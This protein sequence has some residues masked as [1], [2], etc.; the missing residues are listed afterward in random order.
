MLRAIKPL[1]LCLGISTS[2]LPAYSQCTLPA[3]PNP[4]TIDSTFDSFFQQNGP[5]WTGADGSY[6]L[7][8]PDGTNLWY[9]SD[10]FIGTVNPQTRLRSSD[11]F[12]AHNSLTIQN[13]TT[14]SFTTV[15]YPPSTSSYFVPA[16]KGDWFWVGSG[17][18]VEP[19]PDSYQL[20]IMLS[21]WTP[22]IAFAGN[23]LVIV[24]WPDYTIQSITKVALPNTSLEWGS[25][26][27]QVGSDYYI[28][29]LKDPGNDNKVPYVARTT[30]LSYLTEPSKWQYWNAIKNKWMTGQSNATTLSG[31][32]AITP[33]YSVSQMKTTSGSTFY[34][35]TGMNPLNPPFPL[36]NQV[37]TWY[38]C[39]P[40]GPWSSPTVVYTTPEA[41]ANGCKEGT[42]VTYNPKAHPEFT[43]ADGILLTYN[44]NANDSGDLVCANDY[45]PRFLR[46]TIPAVTTSKAP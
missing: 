39:N 15:G 23:S 13:Q 27:L 20:E 35:M 21:Q 18:V 9:W 11:L 4:A 38:S 32:A 45:M 22:K 8:L 31:V 37:T 44:V 26:I 1:L 30:S 19:S 34:L 42:L 6:S 25:Q 16:T 10:S 7:P 46:L 40:Q 12:Q 17:L 33:E 36:W 43:D 28:Y 29:G 2:L 41:G 5:G 24:D 14:G 3:P